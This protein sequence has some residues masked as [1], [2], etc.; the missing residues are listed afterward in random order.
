MSGWNAV[1]ADESLAVGRVYGIFLERTCCRVA[2]VVDHI[3]VLR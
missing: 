1:V 3:A 2:V